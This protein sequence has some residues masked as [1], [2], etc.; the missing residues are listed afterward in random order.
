MGSD[1]GKLELNFTWLS[2]VLAVI[3]YLYLQR[4][5]IVFNSRLNRQPKDTLIFG[6]L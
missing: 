5:P 4:Y 2:D 3:S 6:P 1:S